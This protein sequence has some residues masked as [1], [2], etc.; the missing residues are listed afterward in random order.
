MFFLPDSKIMHTFARK[1]QIQGIADTR[2][3]IHNDFLYPMTAK[4]YKLPKNESLSAKDCK[5]SVNCLVAPNDL[6][7]SYRR[8]VAHFLLWH[9]VHTRKDSRANPHRK[10][11]LLQFLYVF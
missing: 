9:L 2:M 5:K 10:L 7:L 3:T 1:K 8:I 4:K 6:P 11:P